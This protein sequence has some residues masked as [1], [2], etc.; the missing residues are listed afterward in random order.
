MH[1]LSINTEGQSPTCPTTKN[2]DEKFIRVA[3]PQN[4]ILQPLC[5]SLINSFEAPK[6]G[7]TKTMK[8]IN[9]S[10][11]K[12]HRYIYSYWVYDSFGI[13]EI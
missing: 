4:C 1:F 11:K 9:K 5:E 13:T 8:Q 3:R 12:H 6:S 2:W 10:L 7:N